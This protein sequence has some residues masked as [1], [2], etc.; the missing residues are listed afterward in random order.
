MA[1]FGIGD[2]LSLNDGLN[3][4]EVTGTDKG[5]YKLLCIGFD[6]PEFITHDLTVYSYNTEFWISSDEDHLFKLIS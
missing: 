6:V 1:Q 4:Y 2:V 5:Y 3:S